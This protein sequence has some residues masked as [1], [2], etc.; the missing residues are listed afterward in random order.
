MAWSNGYEA[1]ANG[2]ARSDN[3]FTAGTYDHKEWDRGYTDRL[4][5][6]GPNPFEESM[7]KQPNNGFAPN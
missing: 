3:P 4:I 2:Y 5:D 6:A 7:S 1:A